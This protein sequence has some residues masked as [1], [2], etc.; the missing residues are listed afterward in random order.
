MKEYPTESIRNVALISHGNAGKT[1]LA[2]ALLFA[3]GAITRMGKIE[4][5]NTVSDFEEEEVRRK[6][7]LSTAVIPVEFQDHKV[8]LL[9]TPGYT[10]FIGE[11]ISALRVS[12][13][14]LLLIDSVAGVEVGTEIVWGYCD[15][16]KL[17]R[18]VVISKMDRDNASFDRALASARTLSGE[19]SFVPVLLPWGEKQDLKGVIDLFRMKARGADGKT[20]TE[21]PADLTSAAE[22]AHIALVEAAAEGDDSL[23]EKY[24]DG[25]ELSA[26]EV[27]RGAKLAVR[28]GRFVP[29]CLAAGTADVGSILYW[30]RSCSCFPPRPSASRSRPKA[31]P[32]RNR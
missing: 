11:A 4:E 18:M 22:A 17:P 30:S 20:E 23:L 19:T 14:A 29:V 12:D 15:R 31:K 26:E 10:D 6:L 28:S 5:G 9:D 24:L 8:N 7:S 13:S 32:A 25:Q 1:S 3:T 2:E 16:L 21:I 27:M